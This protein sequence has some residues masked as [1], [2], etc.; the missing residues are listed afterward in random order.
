M[1]K[2]MVY[3]PAQ[4]AKKV[5]VCKNTLFNWIKDGKIPKP[6]SDAIGR[7]WDDERLAAVIKYSESRPRFKPTQPVAKRP[8]VLIE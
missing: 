6:K 5:G 3:R 7:F 2:P 8:A 4:V 1:N